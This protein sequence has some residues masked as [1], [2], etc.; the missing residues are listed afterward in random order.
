M[1]TSHLALAAALSLAAGPALAQGECAFTTDME[2]K[3]LSAAFPAWVAVTDAMKECAPNLVVELDQEFRQKQP[4]AFAAEPSLYHIGGVANGTLTPLLNDGT[5][6]PLD[7]YVEQYGQDLSPNQLIRIDGRIM[8]IAMMVN[9]QHLMYR[10][11]IFEELGLEVPTTYA[12]VLEAAEAIRAAGVVEYPIGA[13]MASGWDLAQDFVN[14]YAGFGGE[15]F[16]ESGMTLIDS[17][18]GVKAL[19][20]M[21]ALTEYMDPEFLVSNS[22]Y[23][24]QQ[25]Q[26]GKIAMANLWATRASAMDDAAESQVVGKV[27]M[28]PAP[29]A[30]AGARPA[31]TIWWDGIVIAA[32]VPDEE[33]EAAFRLAM[34]GLSPRTVA[35]HND[36][37]VWLVPGYE[38][39]P[40]A[41]G[42]I[43]TA[44]MGPV[45]YP[46]SVE[47]GLLHTAIG[48]NIA[49]F[50]TGQE[51][52]E[53]S[54]ADAKDAY[55]AAAREAGVL[56]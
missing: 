23:V 44:M 32:N 38:P 11:D 6:R 10:T 27:G 46:S 53:Q 16:D 45:A 24:Q 2:I 40:M 25:F 48:N 9:T 34:E 37:A 20:T 31:T 50:L 28:A 15:F 18:A 42:A 33:A 56:Q 13:T 22:T 1:K 55:T 4:T 14:M 30:E 54:L 51:S 19:E 43:E 12:E 39:G 5:I 47:M 7:A 52:A 29:L 3:H 8:A 35:E 21:K 49:D 17:E 26:Q 36:D 41:T